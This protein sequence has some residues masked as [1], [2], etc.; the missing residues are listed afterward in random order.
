MQNLLSPRENKPTQIM[1][2]KLANL[3]TQ[4]K[5]EIDQREDVE[6]NAYDVEKDSRKIIGKLEKVKSDGNIKI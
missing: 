6:T 4:N 1:E 2:P 3:R 5:V